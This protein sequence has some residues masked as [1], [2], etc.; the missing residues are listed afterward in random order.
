MIETSVFMNLGIGVTVFL[1]SLLFALNMLNMSKPVKILY[2]LGLLVVPFYLEFNSLVFNYGLGMVNW[3]LLIKCLKSFNVDMGDPLKNM[4]YTMKD[5]RMKKYDPKKKKEI[6]KDVH[7]LST[8][9]NVLMMAAPYF[10]TF[11][12]MVY[13]EGQLSTFLNMYNIAETSGFTYFYRSALAAAFYG[14]FMSVMIQN[15]TFGM[16]ILYMA[17]AQ[18][19]FA[20]SYLTKAMSKSTTTFFEEFGYEVG[21]QRPYYQFEKPLVITG[22]G[23]FWTENWHTLLVDIFVVVPK[24]VYKSSGKPMKTVFAL[25]AFLFSG[26]FHDYPIAASTQAISLDSM[27]FFGL[28]GLAVA[29]EY[30]VF[31]TIPRKSMPGIVFG[32]IFG[33]LVMIY[34]SHHFIRPYQDMDLFGELQYAMFEAPRELAEM[35][36]LPVH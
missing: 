8:P 28:Q 9:V 27:I 34:T 23:S 33:N 13:V 4:L 2:V 17:L 31:A 29:F 16:T 1:I 21:D 32:I 3:V 24:S 36:P 12:A 30:F 19:C 10:I 35:L 5:L 22:V 6:E 14:L 11:V 7:Y 20:A 18:I 25:S 26:L 15:L